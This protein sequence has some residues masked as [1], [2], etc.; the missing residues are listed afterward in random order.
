MSFEHIILL[1]Q[2]KENNSKE[3]QF[4]KQNGACKSCNEQA[5]WF[6]HQCDK[7]QKFN[8]EMKNYVQNSLFAARTLTG[9]VNDLMDEAKLESH[10]FVIHEEFFNLV[11]VV[12]HAFSVV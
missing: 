8:S 5:T 11:E 9:L 12:T 6:V 4:K 3:K 1:R 7:L 10:T 2:C